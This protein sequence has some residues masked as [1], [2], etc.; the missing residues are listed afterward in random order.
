MQI[1]NS[2]YIFPCFPILFE[3]LCALKK[4]SQLPVVFVTRTLQSFKCDQLIYVS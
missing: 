2:F 4:I 1:N 3:L